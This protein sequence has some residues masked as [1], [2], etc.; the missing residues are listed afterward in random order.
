[1][2]PEIRFKLTAIRPNTQPIAS[3]CSGY[4]FDKNEGNAKAKT[5]TAGKSHR[6]KA[7]GRPWGMNVPAV[8]SGLRARREEISP[9]GRKSSTPMSKMTATRLRKLD[10]SQSTLNASVMPST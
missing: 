1:M 8:G 5:V 9:L 2:V 4:G 3:T 7:S 10:P 6:G